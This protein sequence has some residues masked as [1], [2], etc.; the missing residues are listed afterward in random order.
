[1]ETA[2]QKPGY[3]ISLF[4]AIG[5]MLITFLLGMYVGVHP[6]WIP[7]KASST[8]DD[9]APARRPMPATEPDRTAP[10]TQ[11]ATTGSK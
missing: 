6:M 5:G 4:A 10:L 9:V 2:P 7:V 11:P 8:V 1:M 3:R